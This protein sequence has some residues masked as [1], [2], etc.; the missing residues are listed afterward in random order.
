MNRISD[1]STDS[2]KH[3]EA[4]SIGRTARDHDCH[5]RSRVIFMLQ[6][7]SRALFT[8]HAAVFSALC[9]G[10]L[11]LSVYVVEHATAQSQGSTTVPA[12]LSGAVNFASFRLPEGHE[13]IATGD[14]RILCSE[15]ANVAGVITAYPNVKIEIIAGQT[16]EITGQ[17]RAGAGASGLAT[18]SAGS[19]GGDVWLE[20]DSIFIR[21]GKVRAGQG[22]DGGF[23]GRG[24]HGGSV[25]MVAD[26]FVGDGSSQVAAGGGGRGGDG[27][28]PR[29]EDGRFIEAG[30][31][32]D[33]GS[34]VIN[35]AQAVAAPEVGTDGSGPG[36][37]CCANGAN[38]APG[39]SYPGAAGGPGGNGA[40]GIRNPLMC[41]GKPGA[42]GGL[43]GNGFGYGGLR[44]EAGGDCCSGTGCNGG[45]GGPGGDGLGGAGG[46]GG[47]G[48]NGAAFRRRVPGAGC[49]WVR[50]SGG[51]G[52]AGG[53]GGHAWGGN[54][55]GGGR[56]G[57]GL[58]PGA[59]GM[60]GAA[61]RVVPGAG[62]AGGNGGMPGPASPDPLFCRN[63][64][65]KPGVAGPAGAAGLATNTPVSGLPGPR[66]GVCTPG[67]Y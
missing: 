60:G 15:S 41:N 67:T 53:A 14:L 10:L 22:G 30:R 62:G 56:G 57:D 65:G 64:G 46:N 7:R 3:R 23:G 26:L 33:A 59:G 18:E 61:G 11:S 9:A 20:A 29:S 12:K 51:D 55:A 31:G 35:V 5:S 43:G 21:G 24:G 4:L 48:G 54:G 36:S 25:F 44:G 8:S 47:N 45:S 37:M 17:I 28:S 13:L 49:S 32:G 42:A 1:A 66:G 2:H 39:M 63:I 52:G 27:L 16:I 19:D 58:T 38:G 50:G 34:L 40:N 6:T